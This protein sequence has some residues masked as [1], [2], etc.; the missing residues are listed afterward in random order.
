VLQGEGQEIMMMK[1]MANKIN[2]NYF[3]NIPSAV[4]CTLTA[5]PLAHCRR[6]ST[7][8]FVNARTEN[9]FPCISLTIRRI[10][11]KFD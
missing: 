1:M 7:A 3:S 5:L 6:K 10:E 9:G 11:K 2:V 4:F 8:T